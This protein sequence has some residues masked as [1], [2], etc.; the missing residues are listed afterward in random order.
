MCP[1]TCFFFLKRTIPPSTKAI[2]TAYVFR[3]ADKLSAAKMRF[4]AQTLCQQ[5]FRRLCDV[6]NISM[7]SVVERSL[8]VGSEGGLD[9]WQSTQLTRDV[10]HDRGSSWGVHVYY[11][12]WQHL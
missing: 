10:M 12:P 1:L 5:A 8:S 7:D 4:L 6:R 11:W 3:C 9:Q 2:S